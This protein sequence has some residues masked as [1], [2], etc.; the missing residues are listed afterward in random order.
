MRAAGTG[1]HGLDGFAPYACLHAQEDLPEIDFRD[2]RACQ[3]W[4]GDHYVPGG[5]GWNRGGA[6]QKE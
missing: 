6:E 3:T 1:H 5:A 4:V 2:L